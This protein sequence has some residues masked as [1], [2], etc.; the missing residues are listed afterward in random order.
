MACS[1]SHRCGIYQPRAGVLKAVQGD[2]GPHLVVAPASLLENWQRELA[3]WCPT[4]A[5]S[6]YHGASRVEVREDWGMWL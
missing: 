3:R 6:V 5:V 1:A 2:P 4:L